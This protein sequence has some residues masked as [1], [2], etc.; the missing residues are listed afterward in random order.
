M[1]E[2]AISGGGV[3]GFGFLGAL[4]QLHEENLLNSIKRI[5]GASIG[6]FIA[7]CLVIG[8]TPKE[9]IDKLFNYNISDIKDLD[10]TGLINR[11]SILKGEKYR[12]MIRDIIKEKEDPNITLNNLYEKTEIELII[13]V[14][15]MNDKKLQ[16]I[17]YK[18]DPDLDIFTLVCMSSAIPGFLPPV[19]YKNKLYI[20][21]GIL[22]N[23]PFTCLSNNSWSICSKTRNRFHKT[24][25]FNFI[26]FFG[27]IIQMI[28]KNVQN[29]IKNRIINKIEIDCG[30]TE[31]TSFNVTK[32]DKIKM[33][34]SGMKSVKDNISQIREK[35]NQS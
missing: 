1:E 23:N 12:E 13:P 20:D 24:E 28:Y 22:D 18:T 34:F 9:I 15:C 25:S 33:I 21:G 14:S 27:T 17:S 35:I 10:I 4:H 8:F 16:Y 26:Y 2:I 19:T 11:K 6:S 30:N 32:D 31:V 29:D 7:V 5:S 3:K